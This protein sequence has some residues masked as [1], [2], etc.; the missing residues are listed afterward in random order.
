MGFH[1]SGSPTPPSLLIYTQWQDSCTVLSLLSCLINIIRKIEGG[2]SH[3]VLAPPCP[4]SNEAFSHSFT[5]YFSV[6]LLRSLWMGPTPP[7]GNIIWPQAKIW[8]I[9]HPSSP[10][11]CKIT[12]KKNKKCGTWALLINV[13]LLWPQLVFLSAL[14]SGWTLFQSPSS[15]RPSLFAGPLYS[16]WE[17]LK[18]GSLEERD[19][20]AAFEDWAVINLREITAHTQLC[21]RAA[22]LQLLWCLF[23]GGRIRFLNHGVVCFAKTLDIC[24]TSVRPGINAQAWVAHAS[25]SSCT[26]PL[27]VSPPSWLAWIFLLIPQLF[28]SCVA[29]SLFINIRS[30]DK[31]YLLQKATESESKNFIWHNCMK[32]N[33][34]SG[35]FIYYWFLLTSY[36]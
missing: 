31:L 16:P 22:C 27:F 19:T 24:R 23:Y 6:G 29:V 35:L 33:C 18:V 17:V 10:S 36:A 5:T 28:S 4:F 8:E 26:H 9:P 3:C 14:L 15:L 25:Q 30:P 32:R 12:S 1:I 7:R 20:P 21:V 34:K 2:P 13:L 11:G